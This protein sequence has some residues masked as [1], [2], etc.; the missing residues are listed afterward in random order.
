[1]R[2][3]LARSLVPGHGR[4]SPTW[5]GEDR[6]QGQ[7]LQLLSSSAAAMAPARF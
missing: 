3:R 5:P 2:R 4:P 6:H 1:M 7:L